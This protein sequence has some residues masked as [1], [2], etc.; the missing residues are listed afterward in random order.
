[1]SKPNAKKT[2]RAHD[3]NRAK[4][5]NGKSEEGK[6]D[7]EIVKDQRSEGVTRRDARQLTGQKYQDD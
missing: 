2:N 4:E 1:M 5:R 6:K 3:T 7:R